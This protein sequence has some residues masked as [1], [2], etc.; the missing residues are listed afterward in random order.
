MRAQ[1]LRALLIGLGIIKVVDL[2][3]TAFPWPLQ[4]LT[5]RAL[6]A[7]IAAGLATWVEDDSKSRILVGLGA[8]GMAHLGHEVQDTLSVTG[9]LQKARVMQM[10]GVQVTGR[11]RA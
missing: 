7:L 10:A 5:K 1:F 2:A 11:Q 9:D 6:V 3:K 8:A 4:P